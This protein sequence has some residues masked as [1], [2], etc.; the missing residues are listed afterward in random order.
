MK[1]LLV[2]ASINPDFGHFRAGQTVLALLAVELAKLVPRLTLGIYGAE[3]ASSRQTL[4]ILGRAGV[5][6]VDLGGTLFEP[7]VPRNRGETLKRYW[8]SLVLND[9]RWDIPRPDS[10]EQL[11]HRIDDIGA[12]AALLYWDTLAEFALPHM[13]TPAFGYLARPPMAAGMAR[14]KEWPSSIRRLLAQA[15]LQARSR[16]HMERMRKLRAASNI[17]AIDAADLQAAGVPCGYISNTWADGEGGEWNSRRASAESEKCELQILANIGAVDATG[18]GYG[19]RYLAERILPAMEKRYGDR[20]WSISICGRGKLPDDV[21]AMLKSPRVSIK[22]FVADID[23]EMR[24]SGIFLLL[25]NMGPYTGGYTRVAY[26]FSTGTC[27]IAAKGLQNSMPEL[28]DGENCLLGSDENDIIEKIGQALDDA[29]LRRR[30]GS[31]ARSTYDSVYHPARVA[32]RI[33]EMIVADRR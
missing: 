17:C 6:V 5:D 1:H 16:R 10:S 23:A 12:D 24:S 15:M 33:V 32:S 4:D 20:S 26:A 18:N 29:S 7:S 27:L 25:N 21:L 8:Q 2:L 22:G 30:L 9:G 3:N 19:L 11:A 14:V 31:A 13:K 28:I